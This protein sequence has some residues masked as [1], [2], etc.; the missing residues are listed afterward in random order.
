MSSHLC[1]EFSKS[2][3]K[4]DCRRRGKKSL[5][6]PTDSKKPIWMYSGLQF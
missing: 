5:L 2:L 4:C 1:Y 6:Y 3:V